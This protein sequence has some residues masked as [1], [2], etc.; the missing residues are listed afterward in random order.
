MT[1]DPKRK[2]NQADSTY[3]IHCLQTDIDLQ[4]FAKR[5]A[6][7]IAYLVALLQRRSHSPSLQQQ[8]KLSLNNKNKPQ[9]LTRFSICKLELNFNACPSALDPLSPTS[10]FHCNQHVSRRDSLQHIKSKKSYEIKYLQTGIVLQRLSQRLA[11]LM[12]N[13]IVPLHGGR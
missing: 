8:H 1:T 5:I 2:E 7:L 4:R 3:K 11:S 12:T 13:L 10:L 9:K 6:S